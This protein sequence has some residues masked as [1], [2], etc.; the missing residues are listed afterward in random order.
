MLDGLK[1]AQRTDIFE[2]TAALIL[3]SELEHR[4][5]KGLA[6]VRMKI[7][8]HIDSVSLRYLDRAE[9]KISAFRVSTDVLPSAAYN[10]MSVCREIF[11]MEEW[12]MMLRAV[13]EDVDDLIYNDE[14]WLISER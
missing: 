3:A 12:M 2:K 1:L 10:V 14:E 13:G 4:F 9:S 6:A 5:V 11:G 8:V 7:F